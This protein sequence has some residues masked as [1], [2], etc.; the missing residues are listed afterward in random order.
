MVQYVPNTSSRTA[1]TSRMVC[2]IKA[3]FVVELC[4]CRAM[5]F[6]SKKRDRWATLNVESIK[7][8][9]SQDD[10]EKKKKGNDY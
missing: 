5:V 7:M 6:R 10:G 1:N 3:S 4:G 2:I 8:L 9:R